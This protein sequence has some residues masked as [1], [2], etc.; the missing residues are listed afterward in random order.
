MNSL[1]V[2]LGVVILFLLGCRESK[3]DSKVSPLV[4]NEINRI[5]LDNN[6]SDQ[7]ISKALV[8]WIPQTFK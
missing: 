4:V 8:R 3:V 2:P 1:L 7:E 5:Q 6:L